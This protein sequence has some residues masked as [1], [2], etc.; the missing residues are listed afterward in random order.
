MHT[1]EILN[2]GEVIN[3][4]VATEEFVETRFPGRYRIAASIPEQRA[5]TMIITA[6]TADA[7]NDAKTVLRGLS[8]VTCPVGTTLSVSAE[9]RGEGDTTLLVSDNFRMPFRARD[10][11]EKVLLAEMAEGIIAFD[12][13]LRESGVWSVSED[14]INES[15][16][17][18]R[19]MRFAGITVFVVEA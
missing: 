17:P 2:N 5:P 7:A 13:P 1:Y 11:R 14:M 19:Q 12:V 15:L 10:G 4:I 8:D 6:I 3:T 18:E 9:L 16:P